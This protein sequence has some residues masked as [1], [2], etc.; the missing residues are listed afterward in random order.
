MIEVIGKNVWIMLSVII[1]G[2]FTYGLWR[3]LLILQPSQII[4]YEHFK[5]IDDSSL[6][7]TCII[8]SVA[9]LQ[10][11][12]GIFIEFVLSMIAKLR[13][14]S[15]ENF[16]CFFWDRFELSSKGQL[17]ENSTRII[18]NCF[19][20]INI[21]VG[22]IILLIYFTMFESLTLSHWTPKLLLIFLAIN[23]LTIFFRI[24]NALSLFGEIKKE[25][26]KN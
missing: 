9:L 7:T 25:T 8:I 4:N 21:L 23:L 19:L 24:N 1:P 20:S 5:R 16:Y 6:I 11:I 13:K 10:Q 3:L 2:C 22:M 15:W 26:D 17:N 18:G 14:N 12:G